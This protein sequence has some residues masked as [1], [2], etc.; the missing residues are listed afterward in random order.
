MGLF[1]KSKEDKQQ[2]KTIKMLWQ[3]IEALRKNQEIL[4]K[5]NDWFIRQIKQLHSDNRKQDS[6]DK[7]VIARLSAQDNL[8]SNHQHLDLA[9][10]INDLQKQVANL[11]QA[12]SQ[13]TTK[14]QGVG[15]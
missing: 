11:Y 15:V 7:Q 5:N 9:K 3:Y 10:T 2:D 14:E 6:F 8:I 13:Q 4:I 12:Y 1:G